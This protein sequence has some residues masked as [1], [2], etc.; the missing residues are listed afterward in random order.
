MNTL[1]LV[2]TPIGNLE[3]ITLRALR[4]LKEV[5]LIAAEDTRTSGVL[6]SHF[7]I[8]TPMTSYHEHNKLDKID[9]IFEVLETDD[10]ALIS[11]A[12]TP[13]IADPGYELVR[14]AIQHGVKI[15]PIPGANAAVS[16]LVASGIATDKFTF[17]GFLP[18]KQ[19]AR[20]QLLEAVKETKYSLIAYESPYRLADTLQLIMNVLGEDRQVCV[21][22]EMTKM[23]EEF[24]RGSARDVLAHYTDENPKGEVTLVISGAPETTTWD[25]SRV[26][27]ALIERIEAGDS[28]SY[29]AKSIAKVSGWKKSVVYKLGVDMDE[30][31]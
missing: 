3:D 23:Y 16:A 2:A 8:S 29:A 19:Y 10:V 21:G 5:A 20:R 25:T 18:K 28:L 15:V 4:I 30:D 9:M 1:Y 7:N 26:Q 31:D 27:D 24:F 22:R 11:D 13:G 6:L 12:G 14:D 17:L